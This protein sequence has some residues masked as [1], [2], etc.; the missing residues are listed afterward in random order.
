MDANKN[1]IKLNQANISPDLL[2]DASGVDLV[3]IYLREIG[4]YP[5]LDSQE[6]LDLARAYRQG[7]RKARERLMM[8]NL[9]LVVY[10]ARDYVARGS[11]SFLDLVQEGNIGLLRAIEKFNPDK[12]YRFSTYAMWWIHHA[13]RRVVA[14]EGRTVRLPLSV[15]QLAQKINAAEQAMVDQHGAPPGNE[16]LAQKLGITVE[17]LVQVKSALQS[18][19]SLDEGVNSD[20]SAK[21]INDILTDDVM[22]S[23][24]KEAFKALWWE[25][26]NRELPRLSP[27]Q[28]EVFKLRYALADGTA[29]TLASIGQRLGISRERARQLEKQALEKLRRSKPLRQLAE[30]IKAESV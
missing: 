28:L 25:A 21:D 14:Q 30:F 17:R 5:L 13:I 29:H 19:V 18:A 27:R 2:G 1:G 20:S 24:E 8:S 6:E 12:G 22:V 26:L 11:L 9:R 7:D 15:I 4:R 10:A 3:G 16:A 23:P